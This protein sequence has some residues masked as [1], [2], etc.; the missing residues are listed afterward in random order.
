MG[1]AGVPNPGDDENCGC[2]VAGVG[3]PLKIGA[4]SLGVDST[5]SIVKS[6]M[7]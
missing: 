7:G 5:S 4:G 2:L 6:L 1:Y 3:T